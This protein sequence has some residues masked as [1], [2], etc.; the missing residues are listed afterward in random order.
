M[1]THGSH[2]AAT[3]R[4]F[5]QLGLGEAVARVLAFVATVYLARTLGAG[6]YGVIV[7]ATAVIMYLTFIADAGMDMIGVRE[8]SAHPDRVPALLGGVIGSRLLLVALLLVGTTI[9][10]LFILPKPDGPALALYA[11]TLVATALGTR[12]VHVG[13]DRAGN[14]AW[15]RVLSET[16]TAVLVLALV[17][18]PEHLLR[19]PIAQI[20]GELSASLLLLRL[21][22][23]SARPH[24]LTIAPSETYALVQR[25]WPMIT[26]GILGLAIFNSD[27]LFL[28]V[29]KGAEQVGHYAVAYTLISFFQ[30]LGVAYTMS[31]IP[32]LTSLRGDKR[33]TQ[34]LVDDAMAQAAFGALPVALGG[35]LVAAPLV[36]MLFGAAYTP[37]VSPLVILLLVI[38]VALLR[39]VLQ[40][41]LVAH[42]RQDRMLLTVTW[43]AGANVV[44]NLAL[45]PRWGMEGAAVATLFTEVVRTVLSA[46]YAA[47]EGVARTPVMRL[48]NVLLATLAMGVVVWPLRG[49]P[50]F[51][52]IPAG[53]A[54]YIAVLLATGAI[55]VRGGLKFAL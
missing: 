26:H 12:F 16:T 28:R 37:S 7:S 31:L 35:V 8:V 19:V 38:P 14:A 36:T 33:A 18:Q 51:V 43:A 45:I 39:N 24:R 6:V 30:N 11:G 27:F 21:L 23:Q 15:S 55:R 29:M 47:D 2:A 3:G 46:R 54:A 17:R 25:A 40:A 22:P 10:G 32:G 53:G 41:V 44:L 5:L 49:Y 20:I 52:S 13:L 34:H 48:R 42:E 4:R 50:A 9:T 1:S